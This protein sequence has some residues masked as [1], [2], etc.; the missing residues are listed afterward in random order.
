[1]SCPTIIRLYFKSVDNIFS[2]QKK[3]V[4]QHLYNYIIIYWQYLFIICVKKNIY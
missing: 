2:G 3:I 4:R 1:M